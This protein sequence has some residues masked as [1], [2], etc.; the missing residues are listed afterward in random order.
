MIDLSLPSDPGSASVAGLRVPPKPA[1][2][3]PAEHALLR[4]GAF[5]PVSRAEREAI[6]A[7][8]LR[9][10]RLTPAEAKRALFFVPVVGWRSAAGVPFSLVNVDADGTTSDATTYNFTSISLGEDVTGGD[11]RYTVVVAGT[12]QGGSIA[13]YDSGTFAGRTASVVSDGSTSAEVS[14][15]PTSDSHCVILIADTSGTGTSGTISITYNGGCQGVGIA[16]YKLVNPSSSMAFDVTIDGADSSGQGSISLNIP[17]GGAAVGGVMCRGGGTYTW[18]G[19][20]EDQEY[21]VQ[22]QE[23]MG[24]ASGGSGGTPHLITVQCSESGPSTMVSASASWG[25]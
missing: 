14:D 6:I 4:P 3:R 2:W 7:D 11:I 20:N 13:S 24:A 15:G 12:T 21:D 17:A 23:V 1:L 16:V 22:S 9:A 18:T 8:L 19:L 25:P 10:K 5:R